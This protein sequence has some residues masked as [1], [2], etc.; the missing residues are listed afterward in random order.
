MPIPDLIIANARLADRPQL[1]DVAIGG[2]RVLGIVPSIAA[3][4]PRFDAG[5]LPLSGGFVDCHIHLDEALILDRTEIVDGT[6]AEAVRETALAKVGFTV[7]DVHR[8]ASEVLRMAI[9]LGTTAMR[10][11]VEV[12]PSAGLRSFEAIKAVRAEFADR[13]DIEICAFARTG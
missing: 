2:G 5:G 13:I 7:D 3:D 1:A 4:A 10:T 9:S 6:L 8:R 12:D 11:F